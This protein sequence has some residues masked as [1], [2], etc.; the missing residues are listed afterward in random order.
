[1]CEITTH[2]LIAHTEV[3]ML[4]L[5]SFHSQFETICFCHYIG[6]KH[7]KLPIAFLQKIFMEI[8]RNAI[9]DLLAIASNQPTTDA[10]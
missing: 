1:M 5:H 7:G 4:T 10:A 8:I 6:Y 3:D 2:L 9:V